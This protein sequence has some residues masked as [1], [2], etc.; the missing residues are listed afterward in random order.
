[1]SIV[2]CII[3]LIISI[4][5][6]EEAQRK[7]KK[8]YKLNPNDTNILNLLFITQYTLVKNNVCEYNI[9]EAISFANKAVELGK[10]DYTPQK[11]ELEN[12]LK[13]I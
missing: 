3:L 7:L 4:S 9:K 6:Y 13:N 12:I 1:M 10:F 8:A 2:C 5:D 11:Q